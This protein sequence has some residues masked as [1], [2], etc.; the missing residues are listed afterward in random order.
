MNEYKEPIEEPNKTKDEIAAEDFARMQIKERKTQGDYKADFDQ[1]LVNKGEDESEELS[2]EEPNKTKDEIAAEDLAMMEIL[3]TKYIGEGEE[4]SAEQPKKQTKIEEVKK[5]EKIKISEEVKKGE[6]VKSSEKVAAEAK[7][8]NKEK[9]DTQ[10]PQEL[11]S[12]D[13]DKLVEEAM[14]DL[15]TLSERKK[16][17]LA[18]K[19]KWDGLAYKLG[20]KKKDPQV[21]EEY[22][23]VYY[24]CDAKIKELVRLTGKS[25]EAIIRDLSGKK[26][27]SEV[28]KGVSEK[29]DGLEKDVRGKEQAQGKERKDLFEKIGIKDRRVKLLIMAAV[30]GG[31]IAFPVGGIAAGAFGLGLGQA[32]GVGTWITYHTA[33]GLVM[34]NA[35]FAVGG[36]GGGGA[37][38]H[39]IM[40]EARELGQEKK[41]ISPNDK[42]EEVIIQEAKIETKKEGVLPLV[43]PASEGKKSTKEPVIQETKIE[44]VKKEPIVE[45]IKNNNAE[46]VTEKVESVKEEPLTFEIEDNGIDFIK[47]ENEGEDESLI[48]EIDDKIS[49]VHD[50]TGLYE[51]LNKLKYSEEV[52]KKIKS[53][54]DLKYQPANLIDE[55]NKIENKDGLREKVKELI[56][57]KI[58]EDKDASTI[59]WVN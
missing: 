58:K 34:G 2:V 15:A 33:A 29:L 46:Q 9:A 56:D 6:E 35:T 16:V 31:M 18:E 49:E 22:D 48:F 39:K 43:D 37:L 27:K 14:K 38:L 36:I 20:I 26:E 51:M 25:K 8:N 50:F 54:E 30:A 24:G 12:E 13:N 44:P 32:L 47:Q 5:P 55:L 41:S 42:A 59:D 52:I 21:K 19:K 45:E 1:H 40:K 11:K 3:N 10:K 53:L 57:K 28:A 23:L 17:L 7:E 4:L